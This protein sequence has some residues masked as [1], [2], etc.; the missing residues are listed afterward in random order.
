MPARGARTA[1]IARSRLYGR[2]SIQLAKQYARRVQP[3]EAVRAFIE[4]FNARDLDALVATLTEDVEIQGSRGLVEGREEVRQWATRKPSGELHQ[5]L[6]LDGMEQHGTHVL[7]ELR[8]QWLWT[9][10]GEPT[11][12]VGDEQTLFYVATIRD[13]LIAR[14]APFE[15]REDALRAAG[16]Q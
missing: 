6:V 12:K 2:G 4:A 11:G 15:R 13:G 16:A 5:R 1:R 7:A 10:H 3:T 9:E 14:W 8:R